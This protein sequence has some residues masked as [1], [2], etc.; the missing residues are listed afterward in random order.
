MTHG[1]K[2]A[3]Y[4]TRGR[5]AQK[6]AGGPRGEASEVNLA[7]RLQEQNRKVEELMASLSQHPSQYFQESPQFAGHMVGGT[8]NPGTDPKHDPKPHPTPTQHSGVKGWV[9]SLQMPLPRPKGSGNQRWSRGSKS[10]SVYFAEKSAGRYYT[11]RPSFWRQKT[12]QG[13]NPWLAPTP[14][15]IRRNP[16]KVTFARIRLAIGVWLEGVP[17]RQNSV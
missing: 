7:I 14:K 12:R 13:A 1:G 2:R 4:T 8:P 10:S 5:R 17:L 3:Q 11:R 15:S 9:G 16:A 6:A